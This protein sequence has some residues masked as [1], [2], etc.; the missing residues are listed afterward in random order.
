MKSYL[1]R[2]LLNVSLVIAIVVSIV[3]T[4]SAQRQGYD[5]SAGSYQTFTGGDFYFANKKFLANNVGQRGVISVGPCTSVDSVNSIPTTGYTIFGVP[6][7][8][9]NCYVALTH[10]DE[11]N[12]IVFRADEVTSAGA[13]ITWKILT[14]DHHGATLVANDPTRRG[15][16]FSLRTYRDVSDGDFYFTNNKFIANNIGQRGVISAG[17]CAS[18]DSVVSIPTTGYTIFGVPAIAG[19]CY[20]ALTHNDERNH[21]VFRADQVTATTASLTWKIITSGNKGATLVADE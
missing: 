11:R 9:G 12:H 21:I 10:N 7:V 17:P 16:D 18:L 6:A 14:S 19:N 8:A 13:S 1:I 2:L 3:E 4:A 5:F 15:Y 20:V